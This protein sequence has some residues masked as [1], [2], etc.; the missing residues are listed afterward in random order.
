MILVYRAQH[1][2]WMS[3]LLTVDIKNALTPE[4]GKT[5]I[6]TVGNT[7]RSDD[8][9][10]PYIASL[11]RVAPKL[12]VIDAGFNPENVIDKAI[13]LA[14]AKIIVIDA[15]DFRDSPGK[16]RI[17][18]EEIIPDTCISTH[19]IPLNVITQLIGQS[20]KTRVIF[21]GIQVK[22]VQL[23]E[24]MCIEVKGAADELIAFIRR[25]YD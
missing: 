10:G 20:I 1:I 11:L 21:I 7:L 23:G 8:G 25:N 2:F 3:N 18:P 24:S 19:S 4:K 15:A 22:N 16:I 9:I 14:P 5:L 12:D 6:I 17:I 13:E